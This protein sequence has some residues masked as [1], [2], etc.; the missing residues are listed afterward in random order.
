MNRKT[1][2]LATVAAIL[3]GCTLGPDLSSAARPA[4]RRC[5]AGRAGFTRPASTDQVIPT[6]PSADAIGWCGSAWGPGADRL[7]NSLV[8]LL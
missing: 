6:G 1:I 8:S 2:A 5:L 4:D 7:R 3:S